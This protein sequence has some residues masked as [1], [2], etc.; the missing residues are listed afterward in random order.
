M[1]EDR[2]SIDALDPKEELSSLVR[3][4]LKQKYDDE[5]MQITEEELKA[6]TK[7]MV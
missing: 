2:R 1:L 4:R 7:L 3:G 5:N 6:V